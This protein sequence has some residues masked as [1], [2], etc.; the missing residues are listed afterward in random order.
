MGIKEKDLQTVEALNTGDFLRV[1]TADGNSRKVDKDA[2]GS[3]PK[4]YRVTFSDNGNDTLTADKTRGEILQAFSDD[5][6][7]VGVLR[8][9]MGSLVADIA[10]FI[11]FRTGVLN[12]DADS[13]G[14]YA[15]DP[16]E[17]ESSTLW[18]KY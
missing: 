3:G 14:H 6:I 15:C 1:V 8:V 16:D 17:D 4:F 9:E 18:S 7:V 2:V 12:F 13:T 11:Y 10:S 5:Y